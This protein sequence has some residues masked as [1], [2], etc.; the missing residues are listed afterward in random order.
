V[1]ASPDAPN[2]TLDLDPMRRLALLWL[3]ASCAQ[4]PKPLTERPLDLIV[5]YAVEP[6]L[7]VLD[8]ERTAGAP[9]EPAGGRIA[10]AAF[11]I[12]GEPGGAPVQDE[13]LWIAASSGEPF[14]GAAPRL[15]GVRSLHGTA[16]VEWWDHHGTRGPTELQSLGSAQG[17]VARSLTTRIAATDLP[18][19]LRLAMVEGCIRLALDD[20]N[21]TLLVLRE[22]LGEPGNTAILFL[23]ARDAKGPTL[24]LA[25]RREAADSPGQLAEAVAKATTAADAK[26]RPHPSS[27]EVLTIARQITVAQAA[28]GAGNRRPALLAIAQRLQ[29]PRIVDLLLCADEPTLVAI[30]AGLPAA[31]DLR[32][33]PETPWHIEQSVF[34]ALLPMLQRDGLP[35]P[36]RAS[37]LRQL[38]A[39]TF[40]P[41]TLELLLQTS[42][43]TS[44]FDAALREENLLALADRNAAPRLRAHEWLLAHGGGVPD[45]DPLGSREERQQ[46]LTRFSV[47]SKPAATTQSD[48][49]QRR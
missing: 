21:G 20:G 2:Q 26:E 30:T 34:L 29:L 13:A 35:P 11:A 25:L 27:A 12:R 19:S 8:G 36:L 14:R 46:A 1:S 47:A 7:A 18:V 6:W 38:G 23:P 22:S 31:A 42:Y 33:E 37:M 39:V 44:L 5:E 24:A 48:Q 17:I 40:D 45:F 16:A 15:R 49:E 10:V 28:V 3:L 41:S 32:Q 4:A 9:S 43:T